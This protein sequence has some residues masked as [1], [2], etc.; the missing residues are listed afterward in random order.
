MALLTAMALQAREEA[1][2]QRAEAERQ[3]TSAEGLVEYMLTDLRDRL[4]GVGRIDVMAAV[5]ARAMEHYR[6]QGDLSR[7]PD[8]SLERRSRILHAMG[9]DDEKSGD[10]E[11]ALA[12]F[13][14][15]HR[16]TAAIRRRRPGEPDAIF[17]HAQ[18]EYWV[19][20]AAW[21]AGDIPR[22]GKHWRR[23]LAEARALVAAEPRSLRGRVEQGYA[24]GNL[25]DLELNGKKDPHAAARHCEAAVAHFA[26]ART[27][28][29]ADLKVKRDLANRLGWLARVQLAQRLHGAAMASRRDEAAILDDLL[30]NDA[31]NAEYRTR[32]SW[33]DIG[34]AQILIDQGRPAEAAEILR[35]RWAAYRPLMLAE[36]NNQYWETGIRIILF[37][38]KA[39]RRMG[40][41][42]LSLSDSAI[43]DFLDRYRR[44]FPDREDELEAL[45]KDIG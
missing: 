37:L 23:Y 12:K 2:R 8:E 6:S 24:E 18:S 5:N 16:A 4:R 29:P 35:R 22:A 17:A 42:N 3:R 28:A 43:G 1:Q 25:C 44:M 13:Q 33:S 7:L 36:R 38:R 20:Y 15:A 34:M 40:S 27:A 10:P 31:D 26:A 14:E 45:K 30:R 39:E 21:R 32:R 9:E 41:S 19:G 11:A